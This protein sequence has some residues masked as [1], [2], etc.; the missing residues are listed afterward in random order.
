MSEY[1][2][3]SSGSEGHIISSKLVETLR[4]QQR[5]KYGENYVE[6]DDFYVEG[7]TTTILP[8]NVT[9][10]DGVDNIAVLNTWIR[11]SGSRWQEKTKFHVLNEENMPHQIVL[12]GDS[13]VELFDAVESR[14]SFLKR[15]FRN[16]APR[17]TRTGQP[18]LPPSIDDV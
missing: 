4:S 2:V 5:A 18:I 13:F 3:W 12:S 14:Q 17:E 10:G 7:S 8:S 15:L 11:I 6:L 1:A 9:D 16:Q